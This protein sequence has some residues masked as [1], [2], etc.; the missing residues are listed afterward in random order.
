MAI[1]ELTRRMGP[2]TWFHPDP[3]PKRPTLKTLR[4]EPLENRS[5]L[6]A[7]PL[8]PLVQVSDPNP[9]LFDTSDIAGQRGTVSL[10]S[11]VEPHLAVD[12]TDPLHVVGVWQQDRWSNGGARGLV[13]G[14]S[15]DGGAN[16]DI[17]AIPKLSPVE[18]GEFKRYTDPWVSFG[19]EGDLYVSALAVTLSGPFPA[20]SAILVAKS[21][22]DGHNWDDP[23]TLDETVA[24]A[25]TNPIDLL[26]DK[27][28]I[29]ADPTRP[30]YA[31]V[32]WDRLNQPSED[33]NFNAFHGFA[34]RTDTLFS[35]TTDGGA[36]W[37]ETRVLFA[38]N[39]NEGGIGH[40]IVV[41]PTMSAHPGRLVDVYGAF[42]GSDSQPAQS[43]R[44]K[45]KMIYSDDAGVTW[46]EPSIIAD[47]FDQAV[48]DP[49]TGGPVRVG[50]PIP[51]VAVDPNN[52]NL[53]VVWDDARFSSKFTYDS[54]AFSMSIDG[55][56]TWSDPIQVNQTPTDIADADQQAFVPSVAVADDGTVAVT[57]YDFRN[58]T[59]ASGLPTDYWMVHAHSDFTDP[60]SWSE[61]NRLTDTS[62][63]ME[64]APISRG[65]FLGDYAGLAAAGD[66]FY[67]LFAQAGEDSGDRSNI[68]FR[69]PLPAGQAAGAA[70]PSALQ[71][72]A[73]SLQLAISPSDA[74]A[75][76]V[77]TTF[78][79]A[80]IAP[81]SSALS[82]A[83][84]QPISA[85]TELEAIASRQARD[86]AF[87]DESLFDVIDDDLLSLLA[88]AV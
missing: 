73:M 56:L 87:A 61:E 58:N 64:N 68:F 70:A 86:E 79:A 16:W 44:D 15:N 76:P 77:Q 28:T 13:A 67:A 74:T 25:G 48:T 47:M 34:F 4:L 24:P 54:I 46:S 31:Y 88:A 7:L 22:D 35:R 80:T 72:L 23:I 39:N 20:N 21:T 52:G 19:P 1:A 66:S 9:L 3:R 50:E 78:T 11:E 10:D 82:V 81:T 14:V 33:A 85:P 59:P 38:P 45:V 60:T 2:S 63:N 37:E 42:Q 84:A 5:L 49:D 53:Y 6:S 43:A 55:G 17:V 30:G 8:T 65:Y 12:P 71:A 62:F 41:M 29:T 75:S 51:E 69:D 40:Q 26:H 27:E 57:Y 36:T 83:Q 32:I 18:G